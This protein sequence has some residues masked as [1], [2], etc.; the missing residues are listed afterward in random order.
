MVV[1][2][3][4][5]DQLVNNDDSTPVAAADAAP[6]VTFDGT[7][8]SYVGPTLIEEGIVEVSMINSADVVFALS[9][10]L[11]EGEALEADLQRTPIGV[12]IWQ[13]PPVH[14]CSAASRRGFPGGRRSIPDQRVAANARDLFAGPQDR[15]SRVA[16]GPNRGRC[17]LTNNGQTDQNARVECPSAHLPGSSAVIVKSG[18]RY[19]RTWQG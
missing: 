10:W 8:C 13:R 19:H 15:R 11:M 9:G 17:S 6:A 16:I 1:V 5:T 12:L 18:R 7:T 2:G 4:M 14:L 3:L